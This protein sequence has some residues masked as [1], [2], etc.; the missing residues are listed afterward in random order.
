MEVACTFYWCHDTWMRSPSNVDINL[1]GWAHSYTYFVRQL[2]FGKANNQ[3]AGIGFW[4]GQNGK[5]LRLS[6]HHDDYTQ[7][8]VCWFK[9]DSIQMLTHSLAIFSSILLLI[10]E[11]P[12]KHFPI[13][14]LFLSMLF[15]FSCLSCFSLSPF[16]ALT[17]NRN[18]ENEKWFG[19][20]CSYIYF[21]R[22]LIGLVCE[23]ISSNEPFILLHYACCYIVL[24]AKVNLSRNIWPPLKESFNRKKWRSEVKWRE[25]EWE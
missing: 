11:I 5:V 19:C 13:L 9:N 4:L 7:T 10:D 2:T 1:M 25:R 12:A 22:S 8:Q 23:F 21:F 15:F 16:H 20:Y 6:H 14:D 18:D 17:S 3:S 24:M